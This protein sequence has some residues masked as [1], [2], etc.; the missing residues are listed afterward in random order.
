MNSADMA[1]WIAGWALAVSI[2]ASV[3]ALIAAGFT[4]WQAITAHRSRKAETER[5]LV[6]WETATWPE[7]TFVEIRSK[8]PDDAW[9]VW[10]RLTADGHSVTCKSK[11]VRPGEVL[12]FEVPS[13]AVAWEVHGLLSIHEGEQWDDVSAFQWGALIT[14]RSRY[15]RPSAARPD[16][17][18]VRKVRAN[19]GPYPHEAKSIE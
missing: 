1:N 8:G 2:L 13:L 14:W 11:R 16:G 18:M 7:A 12:R 10:A 4:G 3:I 15:G 6:E 19:R 9:K 5:G 17:M